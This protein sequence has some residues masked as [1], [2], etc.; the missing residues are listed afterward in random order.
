MRPV[1][2]YGPWIGQRFFGLVIREDRIGRHCRFRIPHVIDISLVWQPTM[3]AGS[4]YLFGRRIW[5][6]PINYDRL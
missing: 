3:W 2:G 1:A 5:L 6:R 4:A